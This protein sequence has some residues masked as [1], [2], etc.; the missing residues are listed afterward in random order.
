[1]VAIC[2]PGAM[3]SRRYSGLRDLNIRGNKI[4]DDGAAKQQRCNQGDAAVMLL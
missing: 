3:Q 4:G 2:L 1:M